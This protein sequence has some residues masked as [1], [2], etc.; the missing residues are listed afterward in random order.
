MI[1]C[2]ATPIKISLG[3]VYNREI[4]TLK[5]K[6]RE[7]RE[8]GAIKSSDP[9]ADLLAGL[10]GGWLSPRDV[11]RALALLLAMTIE[12]ISAFG[13]IVLSSYADA[14]ERRHAA[15][16]E[17]VSAETN[18][19]KPA[20]APGLVIDFLAERIEPAA[21]TD[22]LSQSALY[23]D[24]AAWCRSSDL[25]ALP[26]GDFV[27]GFDQLRAENRLTK[28]RKRKDGYCGICIAASHE[29]PATA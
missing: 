8:R 20:Q 23:A 22:T 11:G 24:Y 6:A 4:A 9:Q 19:E 28:I 5:A 15:R 10:T 2:V 16:R 26:A 7:L 12:F 25:A 27:T 21:S 1:N 18:L 17:E 3:R 29:T 13:P 14:T